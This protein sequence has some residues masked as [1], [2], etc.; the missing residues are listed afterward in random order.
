MPQL[1]S[2]IDKFLRRA[3]LTSGEKLTLC[4]DLGAVS[5]AVSERYIVSGEDYD[6]I[7]PTDAGNVLIFDGSSE[8]FSIELTLSNASGFPAGQV[9]TLKNLSDHTATM[10]IHEDVIIH[11]GTSAIPPG[12]AAQI[13]KRA[14]GYFLWI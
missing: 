5:R 12:G 11:G 14:N 10:S 8:N 9:V 7:L 6:G 13:Y 3:G 1:S 2:I 4:G